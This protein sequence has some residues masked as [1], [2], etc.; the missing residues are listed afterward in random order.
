MAT[1]HLLNRLTTVRSRR[2]GFT[3]L[4]VLV[5]TA[6]LGI[7][8]AIAMSSV[9]NAMHRARQKR[10]MGDL[11]TLALS[12]EAY[13]TDFNRYPAAAGFSL[14]S[15]LVL[16]TVSV[17]RIAGPLSPTYIKAIPI[18]DGWGTPYAYSSNSAFFDYAL[19][20]YGRDQSPQSFP[21]YGPTT[22]FNADIILVDGAFVQFPEGLQK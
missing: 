8:T 14:P 11:R 6:I 19:R 21:A 1:A 9:L 5:V 22:D 18:K 2:R 10:A 16:P 7:L 15:G 4:E 12:I 17:S 20:S 3:L 13:A